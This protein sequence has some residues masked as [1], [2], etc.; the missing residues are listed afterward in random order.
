MKIA[1]MQPYIFPYIGYFQLINA[2]DKF[3]FYDD[4]NYIKKGWINRNRILVN[5]DANL[6]TVPVLKASQNKLINQIEVNQQFFSNWKVKFITTLEQSY[7]KAP[8]YNQTTNIIQKVLNQPYSNI[9][10]LA[11]RSIAD[12]SNY[13]ELPTVFEKSSRSY[14]NTKGM[15]KADRL[16]EICKINAVNIYINPNGGKEL[17][18]KPY[19]KAKNV[20]L[21]F[22]ENKIIP[23]QQFNDSFIGGLSIIDVLMFNSKEDIK[24]MLTQYTLV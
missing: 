1:I 20:D 19:F 6:F 21:F 12:I 13:L 24:N 16:I 17:Y 7:K 4:V 10:D 5:S 15:E 2:V 3:V 9:S 14:A 23:Y 22:I 8:Y 18:N 11:I